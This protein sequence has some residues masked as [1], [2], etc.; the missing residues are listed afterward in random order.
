M[1]NLNIEVDQ[2]EYDRLSKIKAAHG[3]T[4]KG[5]LLQGA[6]SLDTEGPL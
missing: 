1:P 2:D 6:K 5:V 4:W 3:L